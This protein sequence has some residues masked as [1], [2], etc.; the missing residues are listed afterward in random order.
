MTGWTLQ[1]AAAT[2]YTFPTF[3]LPCGGIVKV[4]TDSGTNTAT[5]LWWGRSSAVWNNSGDTATLRDGATVIDT[6]T[7]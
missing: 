7:Y 5:D 6:Y 2:T 1:D 3:T 4:H